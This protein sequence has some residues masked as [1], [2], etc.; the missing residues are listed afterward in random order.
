MRSAFL[1]FTPLV[2]LVRASPTH[3]L[4]E[5]RALVPKG[6]DDGSLV[7]ADTI[8]HFRIALAQS[9]ISGLKDVLD[10][11]SNPS[12][13][14]YGQYL[15]KEQVIERTQ[16]SPSTISAIQDWL[17]S[18]NLVSS[19]VSPFNDWIAFSGSI[20]QANSLLAA[21]FVNH[22]HSESGSSFIRTRS[23]SIPAALKSHIEYIT[24]T[25]SLPSLPPRIAS[26]ESTPAVYQGPVTRATCTGI[27]SPQCLQS[28]YGLP[29][30]SQSGVSNALGIGNLN[31][32]TFMHDYRPDNTAT[33][34]TTVSINGGANSQTVNASAEG[35]MD[36]E[37]TVGLVNNIQVVNYFVGRPT[38]FGDPYTDLFYHIGNATLRPTVLTV[39]YDDVTSFT[40][41][42]R[43]CNAAM[44][45]GNMG[46][47]VLFASGDQG[48]GGLN[49]TA[50]SC[51]TTKFQVAFPASCP[52]VTAVGATTQTSGTSPRLALH[53]LS[54][55]GFSS[56]FARPSYQNTLVGSYLANQN[57]IYAPWQNSTGR[58]LP[59]VSARH[60]GWIVENARTDLDAVGTSMSSPV[61][62]SVIALLNNELIA[63]GK[64]ALGFLNPWL[65]STASAAFKD[66]TAGSDNGCGTGGYAAVSGWDPVTG[67][68]TPL[69]ASLRKAAG[70]A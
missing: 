60:R 28:L 70:L 59:D 4:H 6:Y 3:V 31:S 20:T 12:S 61:F 16:A 25:V 22:T 38:H 33:S 9:N 34:Y 26:T 37:Y 53:V 48:S 64:P 44:V 42:N 46:I 55:G 17:A 19:V 10:E 56:F 65:Y 8:V 63:A 57:P 50:S 27:T 29:T 45:L 32:N 21:D 24:P 35:T 40:H 23:Y 36:M 30:T 66:I 51:G 43:V 13:P 2:A 18:H 14:R 54:G 47:S 15:S 5:A 7:D 39:S 68:G 52:Y 58:A 62:A 11:V 67:L 1:I 69:Y 41:L 49:E